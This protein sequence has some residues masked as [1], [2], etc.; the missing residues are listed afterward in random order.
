MLVVLDS[1]LFASCSPLSQTQ[2]LKLLHGMDFSINSFCSGTGCE[3]T[4][5]K[6]ME[7]AFGTSFLQHNLFC[8]NDPDS[9]TFLR[10][11]WPDT[12]KILFNDMLTMDFQDKTKEYPNLIDGS[13]ATVTP[14]DILI[15]GWPCQDVTTLAW[16]NWLE[17]ARACCRD[18]T[19]RT[20][21]V[22]GKLLEYTLFHRPKL[23]ILENVL[24]LVNRGSLVGMTNYEWVVNQ[25]TEL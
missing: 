5:A 18:K 22:L 10:V 17:G 1:F 19:M 12:V 24:G 11:A 8:D 20:G 7:E 16:Q 2:F 3:I 25:F 21:S 13:A 23:I 15:A 9:H 6:S 14:S 4:V